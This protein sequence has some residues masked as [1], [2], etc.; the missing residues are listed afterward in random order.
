MNKD[1]NPTKIAFIQN[2]H[3]RRSAG[4]PKKKNAMPMILNMTLKKHINHIN[5]LRMIVEQPVS[6]RIIVA[7]QVKISLSRYHLTGTPREIESEAD[8]QT[9]G[10]D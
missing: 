9:H 5:S 3:G 7:F 6:R 4:R 1:D 8:Q 2:S 10:D